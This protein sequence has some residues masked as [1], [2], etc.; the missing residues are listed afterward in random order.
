VDY[1]SSNRGHVSTFYLPLSAVSSIFR[2]Y[3]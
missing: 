1:T 3:L 2:P